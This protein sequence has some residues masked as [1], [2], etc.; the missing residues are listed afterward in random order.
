MRNRAAAGAVLSCGFAVPPANISPIT[1]TQIQ[2]ID[3]IDADPAKSSGRN[4]TAARK[5][6]CIETSNKSRDY[7]VSR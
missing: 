7:G 1:K 2:E 3:F 4:K 6:P 5:A